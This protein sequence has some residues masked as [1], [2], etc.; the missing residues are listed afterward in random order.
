MLR[1]LVVAVLAMLV[2]PSAA[3]AA[4]GD[5][6]DGFDTFDTTRWAVGQHQLGR[7]ALTAPNVSVAGG[8]LALTL[9]DG[10]TDGGEIRS[11]QQYSSGTARARVQVANAPSSITGFFLYAA[12]DYAAEIDIEIFNDP[13]GRVMFSTYAGGRQTH[14]E[15]RTLGFD[16][17]AAAH[18]YTIRWGNGRVRFLVDGVLLRTWSAGVPKAPMH[19]FANAW[20]PAWLDGLAP[21]TPQATLVDEIEYHRS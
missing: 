19:L 16:P 8:A 2:L 18:D 4:A 21:V 6:R 7:S 3:H 13:S 15:T 9:P 1:S 12:P 14:T 11:Q 10:T 17:T 20:F 5:F